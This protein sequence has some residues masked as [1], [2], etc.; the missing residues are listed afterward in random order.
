M[1]MVSVSESAAAE[2]VVPWSGTSFQEEQ[3]TGFV[4]NTYH[5]TFIF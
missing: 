5:L 3:Q 4:Q 1:A 2:T